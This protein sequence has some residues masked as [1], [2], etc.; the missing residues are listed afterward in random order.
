MTSMLDAYNSGQA[1]Q[2]AG[3]VGKSVMTAGDQ[4][5]LSSSQ[6]YGGVS[7]ASAADNVTVS[8]LDSA[9]NVVQTE[10]LGAK[11]AGNLG[12]AWDGK[13][14]SGGTATD[15]TYSFK[16]AAT[17][18]GNSVTATAL[19]LGTVSA[20]TRTSSGFQL[21]LGTLGVVDFSAVQEIL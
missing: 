12:F 15:G 4:L 3:L 13:T 11:A 8:V 16:V 20:V 14:S 9:G 18:G 19:Q 10:N 7:L 1:M 6:A 21:D 5:V 2:A 17:Q